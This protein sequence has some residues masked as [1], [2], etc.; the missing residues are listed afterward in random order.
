MKFFNDLGVRKKLISIFSVICIFIIIIGVQ[1]ISSSEKINSNAEYIYHGNLR[2]IRALSEI[3]SNIH[4]TRGVMVKILYER[5]NLKLDKHLRDI[6]KL[7]QDNIKN[8]EVYDE[9]PDPYDEALAKEQ[10]KVYEEFTNNLDK[11]IKARNKI[12][13]LA[14]EGNYLEADKVYNSEATVISATMIESLEKCIALN[15]DDAE[16]AYLSNVK[17][18]NKVKKSILA[19]TAMIFLI[20]VIMGYVLGKNIMTPL[21][22]I[23]DFAKR[24]SNYEF[25]TPITITRKDEFGQSGVALNTAQENVRSLVKII[26]ENSEDISASAEELSATVEEL[27][28]KVETIDG[29]VDTITC[30]MQ[31]STAASEEISASI[32][33]VNSSMNVL[34]LR[35]TDGS[36]N[37][38]DAKK[39]ANKVK[40]DSTKAIEETRYVYNEKQEKMKAVIEEGKVVD[41]IRIMADTIGGIAQ[42]TNLLALNAAIE[43][44]RA[45]EQGRGF[46]VVAEEVRK[47]AEQSSE[48]VTHIQDT[49]LKVQN[50]F[51]NSNTVC[52]DI[53][54][55]VGEKVND[56]LDSYENT[57]NQYYNDSDF[58]SKM[59]EEI[60]AMSEEVTATIG[61]VSEAIQNM[62]EASQKSSTEALTIKDGM[63]ETTKAIEQVALTAQNQAELAERLNEMVQKFEI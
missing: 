58:V 15:E 2:A 23:K 55:F 26:M 48:A 27:T 19:Y 51:K 53:L 39:R 6:D 36:D 56:Q 18:F 46:A 50:A 5:D 61:Q 34:S 32:E 33:E 21:N 60:A 7:T 17:Q 13:E 1:G 24:L 29:A 37:A 35:A 14:K 62:A 11:Y 63:D 47:L 43:A 59:S 16:E 44:A 49:I 8:M 45:G 10:D 30:G 12:I 4:E 22:K 25:S 41:S 20:I 42:Q 52:H 57:G 9:T 54:E 3:E 28:S 38:N 31:E 40:N